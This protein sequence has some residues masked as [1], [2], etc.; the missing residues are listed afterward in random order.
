MLGSLYLLLWLLAVSVH[1]NENNVD[2]SLDDGYDHDLLSARDWEPISTR[3]M[4]EHQKRALEAKYGA[5][6]EE[7]IDFS[8]EGYDEGVLEKREEEEEEEEVEEEI[9]FSLE[10]Y[11]EGVLEKREEEEEEEEIDFSLEGYDEELITEDLQKRDSSSSSSSGDGSPYDADFESSRDF[12]A[13]WNSESDLAGI[14]ERDDDDDDDEE[15]GEDE[16]EV[17]VEE[18]GEDWVEVVKR[19][20]GWE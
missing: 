17:E 14:F 7:E 18:G 8:L 1:S 19:W 16:D 5:G 13:A 20:V 6:E 9:D 2:T 10:G 4:L 11:D 3:E 15:G 12:L